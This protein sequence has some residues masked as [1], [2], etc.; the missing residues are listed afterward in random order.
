MQLDIKTKDIELTDAIRSH[1]E[2]KMA[3]LDAKVARFGDSV[4]AEVEVGK[5]TSHHHKGE[6]FRAEVHVRL[7]GNTIYAEATHE[8]LYAAVNEAKHDA[9]RQITAYKEKLQDSHQ[10]GDDEAV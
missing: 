10:G 1:I 2:A 5:T 3:S 7:P 8:D 6:I 4:T 9:D